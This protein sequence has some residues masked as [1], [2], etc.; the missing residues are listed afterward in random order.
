MAESACSVRVFLVLTR[1][2]HQSIPTQT[3]LYL[4]GT[5]A[6]TSQNVPMRQS[7]SLQHPSITVT[8][9]PLSATDW[10]GGAMLSKFRD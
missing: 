10:S 6:D 4:F 2:Q 1:V 8:P 7:W 9:K 3:A 5:V